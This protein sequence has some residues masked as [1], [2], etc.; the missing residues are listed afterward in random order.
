MLAKRGLK[1]QEEFNP[2]FVNALRANGQIIFGAEIL[3]IEA[4]KI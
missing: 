3:V 1:L 2:A 4:T